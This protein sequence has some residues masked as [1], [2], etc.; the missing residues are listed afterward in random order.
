MLSCALHGRS[1]ARRELFCEEDLCML[2]RAAW[3]TSRLL[4][5]FRRQAAQVLAA[6]GVA[7]ALASSLAL[8]NLQGGA[9]AETVVDVCRA[10]AQLLQAVPAVGRQLL[11]SGIDGGSC[12]WPAVAAKVAVVGVSN[13]T[14]DCHMW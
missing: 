8:V 5:G 6:A 7:V 4:A 3:L 2:R 13:A 12:H 10:V 1:L 9:A 14:L 11:Q